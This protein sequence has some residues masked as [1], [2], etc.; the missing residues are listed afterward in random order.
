MEG[1]GYRGTLPG[2][3]KEDWCESLFE[4]K[5]IDVF[6]LVFYR[7]KLTAGFGRDAYAERDCPFSSRTSSSVVAATG[8]FCGFG[9]CHVGWCM[10]A[11]DLAKTGVLV[12][13]KC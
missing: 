11:S 9:F 12:L 7:L 6:G 1:C 10:F 4:N 8:V 3:L 13:K 2:A 5:L